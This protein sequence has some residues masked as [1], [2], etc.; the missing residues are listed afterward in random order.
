MFATSEKE[1]K[2]TMAELNVSKKRIFI[3]RTPLPLK[4]VRNN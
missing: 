4:N 1:R 3:M 2:F